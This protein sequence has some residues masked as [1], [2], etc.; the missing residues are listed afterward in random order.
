MQQLLL[1]S[2]EILCGIYL[3]RCESNRGEYIGSSKNIV[4]RCNDH[5]KWLQN[6]WYAVGSIK[7][8]H[9]PYMQNSFNKY[10]AS[11][12]TYHIVET[13]DISNLLSRETYYIQTR[14]PTFNTVQEASR[15]PTHNELSPEQQQRKYNNFIVTKTKNNTFKRSPESVQKTVETKRKS[16]F[17]EQYNPERYCRMVET[18]R[19]NGTLNAPRLRLRG[20]KNPMHAIFM[21]KFMKEQI[22]RMIPEEFKTK[23][24]RLGILNNNCKSKMSFT[25]TITDET[26]ELYAFEWHQ[27]YGIANPQLSRVRH[28]QQN[29]IIDKEK[30][31]WIYVKE[32]TAV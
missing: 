19:K 17:F 18:K 25:N 26:K 7:R 15:P 28:S 24:Y 20:R 16:G 11:S 27:Q 10:G 31:K 22:S 23:Y 30:N 21:K 29:F 32:A 9:K 6:N 5:L 4:N 3:I 13:C 12:F 8:D 1:E 14:N 2:S